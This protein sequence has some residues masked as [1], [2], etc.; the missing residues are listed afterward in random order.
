VHFSQ[1]MQDSTDSVVPPCDDLLDDNTPNKTSG[2]KCSQCAGLSTP[3]SDCL[4][5]SCK[6]SDSPPSNDQPLDLSIH[7]RHK[8][9]ANADTHSEDASDLGDNENSLIKVPQPSTTTKAT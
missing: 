9:S 7:S 6:S 2:D 8:G 4:L 1:T 3:N 5:C